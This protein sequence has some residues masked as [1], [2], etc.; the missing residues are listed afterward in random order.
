MDI[1]EL[2]AKKIEAELHTYHPEVADEEETEVQHSEEAQVPAET[3]DQ[4]AS[5]SQS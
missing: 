1:C 2:C 4:D 5:Q 3:P